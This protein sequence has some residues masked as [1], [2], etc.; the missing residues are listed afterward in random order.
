MKRGKPKIR[1]LEFSRAAGNQLDTRQVS[2]MSSCL[3]PKISVMVSVLVS[4]MAKE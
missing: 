2:F 4:A 3:M 1:R